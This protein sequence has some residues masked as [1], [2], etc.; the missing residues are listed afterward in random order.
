[1]SLPRRAFAVAA[2][3]IGALVVPVV[4]ATTAMAQCPPDGPTT[5]YKF[6]HVSTSSKATNLHSDYIE[7]P[8]TVSYNQSATATVSA[9]MI[10]TVSAEAGVVFA[11]ASASLGV[12]VGASYSKANS[13]TYSKPVPKGKTARLTLFHDTRIFTV[14]K[15]RWNPGRCG[16]NT[17]YSSAV[18]APLK[19]NS[20]NVW[21]LQYR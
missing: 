16:F 6:T 14:T 11:K 18:N 8:A 13:W 21:K 4:T 7:G 19:S 5:I 1:M 20:A 3:M 2:S 9:S 10:A 15:L 12:T 17:V